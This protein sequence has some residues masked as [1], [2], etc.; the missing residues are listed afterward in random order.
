MLRPLALPLLLLVA[1]RSAPEPAE[2]PRHVAPAPPAAP[3][4]DEAADPEAP[5]TPEPAPEPEPSVDELLPAGLTDKG[6]F[7]DLD[8]QTTLALPAW[9]PREDPTL[10]VDA[11]QRTATLLLAGA[12]AKAYPLTAAPPPEA[13][14]AALPLRAGDRAELSALGAVRVTPAKKGALRDRDGDGIPDSVDAMLGA[15]K[16]ALNGA[17]YTEGYEKLAYPG[18]DVARDKGVCT[19]VVVRALRNA[20]LDLQKALHEDM[21]AKPSRYGLGG[22]KPDPSIEHRRVRRLLPWFRAHYVELPTEFDAD[23]T[24]RDAWLPG[25]VVFMETIASRKGPDHVGLVSDLTD[26][27]GQP[28]IVNNWTNG[29]STGDMPLLTFVAITHRFRLGLT[30]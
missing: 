15:R 22:K 12:P 29:F 21:V 11:A 30:R 20:G 26:P 14:L 6:I 10:L 17:A 9:L 24:G 8:A 5:P 19:D 2:A 23:A 16:A 1:C 25:D 13:T 3:A 28:Q 18:G 27:T 4:P 7:P